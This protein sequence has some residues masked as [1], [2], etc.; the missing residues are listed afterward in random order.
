MAATVHTVLEYSAIALGAWIYR[1]S[2]R[3]FGKSGLMEP[4]S[5][6]VLVGLLA[7]A[8]IG[9]KL[10][11]LIERPDTIAAWFRGEWVLPGQSL[12]GGLLGG[13]LGVELAKKITSQPDSTG[14]LLVL[15]IAVGVMLGRVGCFLAGLHDDTYGI[16]TAVPW[17]VD[18]GDGLA[19]HPTQ[20]YEIA[21]V[22]TWGGVLLYMRKIWAST[23]G[24]MFKLFLAGYLV[25]RLFVENIKPLKFGYVGNLSGIQIVCLAALVL[26]GP[27]V[28]ASGKRIFERNP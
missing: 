2:R 19:R 6:A 15:P 23:P 20:L 1:R 4:G 5:F 12:V 26:Y 7:G 17:G 25:W 10:V 9:N 18:F 11:F 3:Q 8:A 27:F 13:L 16:S 21:F 14:D 24:L 22:G 28:L